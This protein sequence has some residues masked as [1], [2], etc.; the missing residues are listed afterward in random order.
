MKHKHLIAFLQLEHVA[1]CCLMILWKH[2]CIFW[3][4]S[5]ICNELSLYLCEYILE[6]FIIWVWSWNL[7]IFQASFCKFKFEWFFLHFHFQVRAEECF[8]TIV[9]SCITIVTGPPRAELCWAWQCSIV[10]FAHG[11]SS[12]PW[13]RASRSWLCSRSWQFA[14]QALGCSRSWWLTSSSWHL[15]KNWFLIGLSL[16]YFEA[17]I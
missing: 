2:Y 9:I 14:R 6:V 17:F 15:K 5:D 12:R 3:F 10:W 11:L 16:V 1:N 4:I 7:C 13:H 8:L